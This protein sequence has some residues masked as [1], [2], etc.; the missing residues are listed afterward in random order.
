MKRHYMEATEIHPMGQPL[1]FV[2]RIASFPSATKL[3]VFP[4]K[5]LTILLPEFQWLYPHNLRKRQTV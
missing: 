4:L 1:L 3:L 2:S 5:R